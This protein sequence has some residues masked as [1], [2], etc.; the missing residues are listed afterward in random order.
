LPANLPSGIVHRSAAELLNRPVLEHLLCNNVP[1]QQVKDLLMC[2]TLERGPGI[3]CDLKLYWSPGRTLPKLKSPVLL[4]TELAIDGCFCPTTR[5][6]PSR[7]FDTPCRAQPWLG[8]MAR[9]GWGDDGFF[10]NLADRIYGF[11]D[12][13]AEK[14]QSKKMEP[15]DWGIRQREWMVNSKFVFDLAETAGRTASFLPPHVIVPTPP[16][17]TNA[18][19]QRRGSLIVPGLHEMMNDPRVV[20]L[21]IWSRQWHI[22]FRRAARVM[23]WE[24]V[25]SSRAPHFSSALIHDAVLETLHT[26]E[27]FM[28]PPISLYH[29]VAAHALELAGSV[30]AIDVMRR[31]EIW[32]EEFGA[33][34]VL[35]AVQRDVPLD[36]QQSLLSF[37]RA[38]AR[39]GRVVWAQKLFLVAMNACEVGEVGGGGSRSRS[40]SD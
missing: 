15:R 23:Y 5:A 18:L 22:D 32:K 31:R 26:L 24:K 19:G 9:T 37:I 40:L 10:A 38:L 8:F 20:T 12:E 3:A 7:Y 30:P 29:Q 6:V 28:P 36:K 16:W 11:W 2:K 25:T 39:P 33:A 1:P 17:M 35:C 21:T 13:L 14:I 34:I 4:A 27:P